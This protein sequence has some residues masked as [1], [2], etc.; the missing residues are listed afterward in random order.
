M[1]D[2]LDH[3]GT[4]RGDSQSWKAIAVSHLKVFGGSFPRKSSFFFACSTVLREAEPP[5]KKKHVNE[6][7]FERRLKERVNDG[8]AVVE[9]E[10][11]HIYHYLSL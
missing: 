9:V 4:L 11:Y 5:P 2:H 3:L 1:M 8:T 10:L 6:N 7:S